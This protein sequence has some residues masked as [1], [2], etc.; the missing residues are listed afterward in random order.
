MVEEEG[1][2]PDD[3]GITSCTQLSA[4]VNSATI[5]WS[6]EMRGNTSYEKDLDIGFV[7]L[8][9][10]EIYAEAWSLPRAPFIYRLDSG[11]L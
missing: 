11:G 1:S 2:Q 5:V 6:L 10:Q 3:R 8:Q 4:G 7:S 9:R